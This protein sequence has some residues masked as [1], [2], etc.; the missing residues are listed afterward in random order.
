VAPPGSAPA[1][2]GISIDGFCAFG[3]AAP[4]APSAAPPTSSTSSTSSVLSDPS[5]PLA[6][7]FPSTLEA[8]STAF[9]DAT[10]AARA[11]ARALASPRRGD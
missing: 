2:G 7:P 3:T 6:S 11:L 10:R 1:A 4:R 8:N 9:V 5:S